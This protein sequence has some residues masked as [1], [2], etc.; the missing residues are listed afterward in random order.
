MFEV[1]P[2]QTVADALDLAVRRLAHV[3]DARRDALELWGA[4]TG[5]SAARVWLGRRAAAPEDVVARYLAAVERRARG[6]PL[7][8]VTGR[9]GFRTLELGVDA[10]VLIP[11]PE[12]EGL[13]EHVLRWAARRWGDDA[14]GDALDIGTGSGCIAL[15]LAAEGRFRSITAVDRSADA[16][17]VARENAARTPGGC[18]VRFCEA[19]LLGPGDERFDVIVSNPPYV[20][21]AEYAALD[22]A[23]RD[24][25]P[26]MALVSGADGL[27]HTRA[28]TSRAAQRLTPGGL[29]AL[30]VDSRRADSVLALVS[31]A[32]WRHARIE[33]DLF[34]RPR[35]VLATRSRE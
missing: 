25:E 2:A 5:E 9:V 33:N 15:S 24:F 3:P 28:I 20:T 18:R 21:E 32:E 31:S 14:W 22:P 30:E 34:G 10:R 26:P 4:I 13:V 8:Y 17:E 11:R 16:L 7:A 29:L 12:T 19:D 1:A 27:A 23:V 35:Y 6:E